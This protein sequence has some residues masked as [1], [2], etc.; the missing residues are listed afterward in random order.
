MDVAFGAELAV[1]LADGTS[2]VHRRIDAGWQVE[3]HAGDA[4]STIDLA[5][6]VAAPTAAASGDLDAAQRASLLVGRDGATVI[7]LGERHYRRSEESWRD[8]GQPT[9]TVTVS[10][11]PASLRLGISVAPS[12]LN[13]ATADAI[14][15]YD[16][17]PADRQRRCAALSAHRSRTEWLAVGFPSRIERG[18]HSP[19]RRLTTPQ[20]MH[21]EWRPSGAGYQIDVEI[22]GTHWR[23]RNRQRNARGGTAARPARAERWEGEFG[24][25][26]ATATS[27]SGSCTSRC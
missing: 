14:N 5:G 6:F 18:H 19:H 4:R 16:N 9:A 21:A 3:L 2:H 26:V 8:A 20:P 13:F 11:A 7:E 22:Q 25:S 17:E 10:R 27:L 23:G 24:I 15:R 12:D 1:K